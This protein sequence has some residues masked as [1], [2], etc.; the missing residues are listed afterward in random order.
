[1]RLF[2]LMLCT[3]LTSTTAVSAPPEHAHVDTEA[4]PWTSLE[5]NN[6]PDVFRFAVVTDNA[7]GPRWGIFGEAMDKINLMQ[8][9]FVM[10]IGD[11]IEGY[12]DT[13]EGLQAQ[14][15]RFQA[16]VDTLEMPFFFVPGNHDNGRAMWAE[17][18]NER[19]GVPYYHFVYK[20]VLFLCLST[21]DGPTHGTGISQAQVD[22]VAATLEEHPD[23]RWTLV[24]Q[25]KPL[26]EDDSQA[27]WKQIQAMLAG[28]NCT[29]F[30][31][32]KHRYLSHEEDGISFIT[33]ATTGGGSPLRGIAYGEFDQIAWVT[34]TENG[35]RIANILLDG[36]LPQDF[37]TPSLVEELSLFESGRA[38]IATP[39]LL[40][41]TTFTSGVSNFTIANPSDKPLRVKVLIETAPGIQV[42]PGTVATTVPGKGSETVELRVQAAEAMPVAQVQPVVL[43]WQGFYDSRENAGSLELSGQVR[44]PVDAP[45]T[46][47][48]AAAPVTVDGNLDE[49]ANLP[50]H[51][52]QPSDIFVN[53]DAWKGP[54]DAQYRFAVARDEEMLYVAI[55]VKDDEPYFDGW[56]YWED[57][58]LVMVDAR[59][60][61]TDDPRAGIFSVMVGPGV[62]PEQAA[63]YSAG[64]A[65]EGTQKAAL[66]LP[67]GFT[68]EI[69]IPLAYLDELQGGAWERVRLNVSVSD[70]DTRDSR[71]GVTILHWRPDWRGRNAYPQAGVF[72][73]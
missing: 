16:D 45:H 43:H 58:A 67:D 73:K 59:A 9:E 34:M 41:D 20:N 19:Y 71:D 35:P 53:V 18:Y 12:E 24:F 39:I 26:W 22:Y 66:A 11:Y 32:H 21:N 36:I 13:R 6:H 72:R 57:F 30:A 38:M 47:P 29:V 10:S 68:A 55:E 15:E 25:H 17:I 65:P 40:E 23:V 28:R 54:E 70:F 1:M 46:I 51:V 33:M 50:F 44:V 56:K 62:S 4:K 49:W 37:R 3:A 64:T 60:S 8:P 2:A 14:W 63:A 7:G 69:A 42:I 52:T 48:V 31:G 61:Y 27:E 5:F